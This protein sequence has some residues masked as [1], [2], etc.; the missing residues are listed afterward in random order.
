LNRKMDPETAMHTL[1]YMMSLNGLDDMYATIDLALIDL[2]EG[3]LWAWKA[4]SMS[5]YIKRGDDYF[6][7]D[8]MSV[9][10]GF[11]PSFSVKA[12]QVKLKA[13]DLLVMMTDGIFQGDVALELQEKVLYGILEKYGHLHCDEV[14]NRVVNEM[15][16]RFQAAGDDRTV[17]VMKIN[18]VQNEWSSFTPYSQAGS[19]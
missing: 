9:P 3:K 14:A 16:R 17:L 8:S 11:L 13:G 5:T 1:H 7:I 15:E 10:V 19:R 4:G 18:H 6:R 12:N 2:Q